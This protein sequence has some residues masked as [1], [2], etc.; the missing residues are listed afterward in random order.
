MKCENVV[1]ILNERF[2]L[3]QPNWSA[4]IILTKASQNFLIYLCIID[5]C[6]ADTCCRARLDSNGSKS[7]LSAAPQI[8]PGT[9]WH[10]VAMVMR[11]ASVDVKAAA[12]L[13]P[14]MCTWQHQAQLC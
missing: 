5:Q 14:A 9:L 2:K 7:K 8:P 13:I 4:W 11:P 12:M 3:K 6:T 10:C 1:P